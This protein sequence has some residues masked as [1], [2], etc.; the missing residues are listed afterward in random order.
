MSAED[1]WDGTA[2]AM[3]AAR[4]DVVELRQECYFTRGDLDF[5]ARTAI[6]RFFEQRD[7]FQLDETQARQAA[8]DWVSDDLDD[9]AAVNRLLD[10]PTGSFTYSRHEVDQA[11]QDALGLFFEL[12]D[13]HGYDEDH[14]Q[15]AALREVAEGADQRDDEKQHGDPR[16]QEVA[17]LQPTTRDVATLRHTPQEP[18][19]EAGEDPATVCADYT[20]PR[21]DELG[22]VTDM[23]A[24]PEPHTYADTAQEKVAEQ[25][26]TVADTTGEAP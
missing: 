6:I 5:A 13:Q 23:E 18:G 24:H 9:T 25:V 15:A 7:Q 10:L 12:R 17:S 2:G 16:D 20:F 11:A 22:P 1:E 8:L 26:R 19:I 4:T 14:A 21:N 3:H